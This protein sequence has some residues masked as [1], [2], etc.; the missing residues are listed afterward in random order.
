MV[1][2][3]EMEIMLFYIKHIEK[4]CVDPVRGLDIREFYIREAKKLVEKL[5][6]PFAKDL[7]K[8]KIREYSG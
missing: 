5:E 1:E 3:D 4:P 6:N 2:I 7:L 8:I